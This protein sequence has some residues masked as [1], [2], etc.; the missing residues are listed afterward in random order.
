MNRDF[1]VRFAAGLFNIHFS[2]FP[3]SMDVYAP[4][5]AVWILCSR[6]LLLPLLTESIWQPSHRAMHSFLGYCLQALAYANYGN[7]M[8]LELLH[9]FRP[10]QLPLETLFDHGLQGNIQGPRHASAELQN[11]FRA[12]ECV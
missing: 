10:D 12:A 11:L 9:K 2:V 3:V 4:C 8:E 6:H 7:Y 1:I 5:Y